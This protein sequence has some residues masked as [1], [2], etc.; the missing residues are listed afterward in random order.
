MKGPSMIDDRNQDKIQAVKKL[1]ARTLDIPEDELGPDTSMDNTP[2]WDS[3]EHMNI[4]LSF[5]REF[6]IKLNM[7]IIASGTSI[8][9][10]AKFIS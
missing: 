8:R 10:L 9:A 6:G 3:C 5:E 4:C 7:D 1:V 2:A